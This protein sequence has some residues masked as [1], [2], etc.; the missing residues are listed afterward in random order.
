MDDQDQ[1][2]K[3]VKLSQDANGTVP[4]N[5]VTATN[6]DAEVQKELRAGISAYTAPHVSGFSGTLKQ[7]YLNPLA[8]NCSVL[9][10][11]L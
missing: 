5:A 3:R 10:S 9:I 4:A 2:R 8:L 11:C 7:R 1:P 6:N